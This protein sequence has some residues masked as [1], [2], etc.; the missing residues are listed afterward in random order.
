M[1]CL[2]GFAICGYAFESL[3]PKPLPFFRLGIANIPV[4]YLII[5]NKFLLSFFVAIGKVVGGNLLVG[6]LFSV[7][8]VFSFS[9]TVVACLFMINSR[10]FLKTLGIVGVSVIG[11]YVSSLVQ[12]YLAS[13][14]L[15]DNL[16]Y[17]FAP[18]SLTSIFSGIVV[19]ITVFYIDDNL[20]MK[21]TW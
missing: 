5:K 1:A 7:Q 8:F 4:L 13:I 6:T 21:L 14:M 2:T 17:L 3:I 16:F 12:L 11:A 19:G 18:F 10:I 15:S 20:E 9:G